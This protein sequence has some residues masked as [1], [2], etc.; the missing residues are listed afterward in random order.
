MN[1]KTISFPL[2]NSGFL[3]VISNSFCDFLL[4]GTSRSTAKLKPLHGAIAKDLAQRLGAGYC[5]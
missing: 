3:D 5:I 4:S 1:Q 2:N